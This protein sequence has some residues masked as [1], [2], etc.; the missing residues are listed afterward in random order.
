MKVE[1][2]FIALGGFCIPLALFLNFIGYSSNDMFSF[3]ISVVGFFAGIFM[4]Y[5]NAK[6]ILSHIDKVH[7]KRFNEGHYDGFNYAAKLIEDDCR[8]QVLEIAEHYSHIKESK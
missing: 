5:S 3:S 7:W 4:I 1:I 8:D 2:F 6:R